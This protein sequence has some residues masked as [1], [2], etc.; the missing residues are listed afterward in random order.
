VSRP[1]A[2][3]AGGAAAFLWGALERIDMRVFRNDYSARG[4]PGVGHLFNLRGFA[5]ATMRHALFGA[6]LARL[7]SARA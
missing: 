6:V 1:K 2:A 3:L 5:Q 7:A 4:E